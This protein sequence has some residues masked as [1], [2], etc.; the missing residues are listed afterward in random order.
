MEAK[1]KTFE[2]ACQALGLHPN[3]LPDV[4][5][6]PEKHR[7]ALLCTY[8]LFIVAEALNEGWQPNWNDTDECKYYPW[9]EVNAS[10]EQP[11]G[12]GLSYRG[13]DFGY[14]DTVVGSR[15]LYKSWELAKYAGIQFKE[16]YEG[17]FLIGK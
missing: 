15:L 3:N 8:K 1:I 10:E 11:S 17:A 6:I 4:S 13:F 16:L 12:F 14:D 2:E 5:M 9:M 7:N